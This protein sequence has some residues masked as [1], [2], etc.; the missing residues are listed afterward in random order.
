MVLKKLKQVNN[1]TV[2]QAGPLTEFVA[3]LFAVAGM[4]AAH[5]TESAKVLVD[6]DL[7]GI[8]TH[9][10]CYNLDLHYLAGLLDGYINARPECTVVHE[11]PSTALVD[12]DQGVSMIS[13]RFGMNLAIEKAKAVG[14]ACVAVK[15]SSHYGAAGYYARMAVPHDIETDVLGHVYVE[16]NS[17]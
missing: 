14:S 2:V 12:G 11:T 7:N 17:F 9:G 4:S 15:N 8:D 1:P 3:S 5:A 13:G 16:F 10:V 6:A